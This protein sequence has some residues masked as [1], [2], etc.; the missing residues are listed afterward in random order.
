MKLKTKF[1]T[2][3]GIVLILSF[4]ITF[5]WMS[6]FQNEL[7]VSQAKQQ[8]RMLAQQVILTRKWVADHHGI[9]LEHQPGVT[10][11]PFLEIPSIID[12]TQKKYF[13]YNPAKVT[14]E[15][16]EY[17]SNIDLWQYKITS[18]NPVNPVNQPDS[19]ERVSLLEFAKGVDEISTIENHKEGRTLRLMLPVMTENACLEC[20][21]RHGYRAGDVRGALSLSISLKQADALIKKNN[22]ILLVFSIAAIFLSTLVIYFLIDLFI[23]RKLKI[24]SQQMVRFPHSANTP[25]KIQAGRDEI[26]DLSRKFQEL[27]MRLIDSQVELEKTREQIYQSEKLAALGRFSAGIAHEINNPLGGMLNCVKS[28]KEAPENKELRKRYFEL[29]E[30][31][32]K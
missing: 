28:I 13:K 20:H 7:V 1:I 17:A 9:Y 32:L 25:L 21:S 30:K 26:G 3:S 15:L 31:G 23:V 10:A 16:S 8:A 18:L 5:Y 12:Q 24:I 14:R 2:A 19:F 11:N 4:A 6:R 22:G 27:N 29:I